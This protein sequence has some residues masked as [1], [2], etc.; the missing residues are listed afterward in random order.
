M[1]LEEWLCLKLAGELSDVATRL[2]SKLQL[3]M[4]TSG[5]VPLA[6]RVRLCPGR[7]RHQVELLL[8]V[9]LH[10][11]WFKDR[12]RRNVGFE[13]YFSPAITCSFW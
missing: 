8:P 9:V 5:S 3:F 12:P 4:S 1:S 6:E 10:E 13:C 7:H 11:Y 2:S